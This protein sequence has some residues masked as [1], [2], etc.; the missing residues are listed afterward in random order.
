MPFAVI[1]YR[2]TPGSIWPVRVP[3]GSPSSA[4]NPIV[5]S[6]LRPPWMAHMEAPLPRC[7]TI[8]RALAISGATSGRVFAMYS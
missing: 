3:I 7:A 6:T 1:R 4:V 2:T 8:T 5:L